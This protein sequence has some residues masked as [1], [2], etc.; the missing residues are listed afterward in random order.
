MALFETLFSVD[1]RHGYYDDGISRDFSVQP[2]QGTCRRLR[3][4]G[5][6]FRTTPEGF[7][8][9]AEVRQTDSGYKSVRRPQS[10]IRYR[11]LLL[12]K[13][14][15][16]L[17]YTDLPFHRQGR[18]IHYFNNL[19]EHTSDGISYLHPTPLNA[20]G[21]KVLSLEKG[22]Y[23]F[24]TAGSGE[25]K[26]ARLIFPDDGLAID[27]E[28][29]NQDGQFRFQ[30]NLAGYPRGRARLEVEGSTR[31]TFY[32]TGG[33]ELDGCF[34]IVEL[35]HAPAVPASYRFLQDDGGLIPRRFAIRF[36]RRKIHWRYELVDRTGQDLDQPNVVED[37]GGSEEKFFK[38]ETPASYPSNR[39]RFVSEHAIPFREEGNASITLTKRVNTENKAVYDSL[40]NPSVHALRKDES[41]E[42]RYYAQVNLYI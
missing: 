26:S 36:E 19:E 37:F 16:F 14:P 29:N 31:D 20:S 33:S 11:F 18:E 12:Q 27:R 42:T 6:L 5:M 8:V 15:H 22:I 1:L 21:A 35:F 28:A 30:F 34:G 41:D 3:D 24:E 32:S 17:N 2:S 40:P 39:K 10:P 38:D 13:R 4:H 25:R 7:L 23:S 9:L